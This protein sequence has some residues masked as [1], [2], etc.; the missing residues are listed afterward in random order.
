MIMRKNILFL[1]PLFLLISNIGFCQNN[2]IH[3]KIEGIW[4]YYAGYGEITEFLYIQEINDSYLIIDSDTDDDGSVKGI[5]KL[6]S[7]NTI[8]VKLRKLTY[9]LVYGSEG[10]DEWIEMYLSPNDEEYPVYERIEKFS[11]DKF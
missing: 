4:V 9:K 1:L 8:E 6:I 5:G 11:I 2:K 10:P 3:K 7:E